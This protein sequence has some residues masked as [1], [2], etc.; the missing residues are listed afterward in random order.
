MEDDWVTNFFDTSR[1]VSDDIMQQLWAKVLA[2]EANSPGTYSKRSVAFL[3]ALDKKDAADFG[4]LC[5]FIWK[6]GR[7]LV[8]LIYDTHEP[9]YKAGGVDFELLTH[10][11]DIGLV[12]FSHVAGYEFTGFPKKS[13]VYYH[14]EPLIIH[15]ADVTTKIQVGKALLTEIGKQLAPLADGQPVPGFVDYIFKK[16]NKAHLS[17]MRSEVNEAGKPIAS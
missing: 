15:V 13:L 9:I 3:A 17:P 10:L 4:K 8:P 16:W 14:G 7:D 1:L 2:G 6:F 5:G 11:N 12:R